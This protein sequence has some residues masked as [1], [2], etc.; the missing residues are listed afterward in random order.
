MQASQRGGDAHVIRSEA[1]RH[2]A[3]DQ[4]DVRD[5]RQTWAGQGL[6]TKAD[7]RQATR[8]K[9]GTARQDRRG[10]TSKALC[11]ALLSAPHSTLRGSP[12]PQSLKAVQLLSPDLW[13]RSQYRRSGTRE[14]G[15]A[16]P[17]AAG[18]VAA[19]SAP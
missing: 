3:T 7:Q 9:L 5:H 13:G 19:T 14:R 17:T 11:F 10:H 18:K 4:A 1:A 16:M 6:H 8:D 2:M 15:R 12:V